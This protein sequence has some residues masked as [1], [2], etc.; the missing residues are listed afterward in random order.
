MSLAHPIFN[1]VD[2]QHRLEYS[3][4]QDRML[5]L[6]SFFSLNFVISSKRKS[7]PLSLSPSSE[8]SFRYRRHLK[9]F[10]KLLDIVL[11]S[12]I[13]CFLKCQAFRFIFCRLWFQFSDCLISDFPIFFVPDLCIL[14]FESPKGIDTTNWLTKSAPPSFGCFQKFMDGSHLFL[15]SRN[16][17]LF[18]WFGELDLW[19]EVKTF[20]GDFDRNH[21]LIGS[22]KAVCRLNTWPAGK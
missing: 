14:K 13:N 21:F 12:S 8:K 7:N 9:K 6:W 11:L 17:G 22:E 2:Y 18:H 10:L 19:G 4:H 5:S 20:C 3:D 1:H 15:D 16:S